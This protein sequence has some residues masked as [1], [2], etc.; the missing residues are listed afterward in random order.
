MRSTCLETQKEQLNH[1][2]YQ[3]KVYKRNKRFSPEFIE[4][5]YDLRSATSKLKDK[6]ESTEEG[7]C[8][9]LQQYKPSPFKVLLYI[10]KSNKISFQ[11]AIEYAAIKDR[12]LFETLTN[13]QAIHPKEFGNNK[14]EENL[15]NKNIDGIDQVC[16]CIDDELD[17]KYGSKNNKYGQDLTEDEE[18]IVTSVF[19]GP[20][21]KELDGIELYPIKPKSILCKT[22]KDTHLTYAHGIV[23]ALSREQTRKYCESQTIIENK[24]ISQIHRKFANAV[25]LCKTETVNLTGAEKVKSYIKCMSEQL[26]SKK[27]TKKLTSK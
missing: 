18:A 26:S 6:Y 27:E 23:G 19:T 2:E 13:P 1:N 3:I 10:C 16:I 15:S 17:K 4:T 5:Y 22:I 9:E 21:G 20:D 12:S 7:D 11:K 14:S 8:L 24:K 25:K